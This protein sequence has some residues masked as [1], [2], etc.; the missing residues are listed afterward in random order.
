[1]IEWGGWA[2]D[3]LRDEVVVPTRVK[4]TRSEAKAFAFL[5]RNE[6]NFVTKEE[7][8]EVSGSKNVTTTYAL[9]G[10]I[11]RKLRDACL[12]IP[13]TKFNV[14]YALRHAL[15][16]DPHERDVADLLARELEATAPHAA[17]VAAKISKI[18]RPQKRN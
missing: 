10:C 15:G 14:G 17:A 4:F 11:V 2:F 9:M 8:M 7:V 13:E 12:P 5:L 1:M 3:E 16:F 6:G 18:Y